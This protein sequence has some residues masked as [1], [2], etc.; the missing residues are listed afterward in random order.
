MSPTP[1]V[2]ATTRFDLDLSPF[3]RLSRQA[4]AS[5]VQAGVTF[6]DAKLACQV[7]RDTGR[8]REGVGLLPS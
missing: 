5:E 4:E 1:I 7:S 3:I 8:E 6:E 2:G